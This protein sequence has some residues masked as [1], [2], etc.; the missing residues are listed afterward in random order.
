VDG[1]EGTGLMTEF[2]DIPE[3]PYDFQ[4]VPRY[5]GGNRVTKNKLNPVAIKIP[6]VSGRGISS[7]AGPDADH[8]YWNLVVGAMFLLFLLYVVAHN[9]LQT[10]ANILFWKPAAPV[11]VAA[12]SSA[13]PSSA[14]LAAVGGN[15]T[16]QAATG[17]A[18]AGALGLPSWLGGLSGGLQGGAISA[19]GIISSIPNAVTGQTGSGVATPATPWGS[20]PGG[21]LGSGFWNGPAGSILKQFGYGK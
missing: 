2:S 13:A 15:V 19:P 16:G 5:R 8:G 4:N 11:Q 18:Q 17:A 14:P 6:K 3:D 12:A 9:E 20:G 21:I 10:W 1:W 7:Q